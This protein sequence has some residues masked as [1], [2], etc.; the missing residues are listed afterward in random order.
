MA[1]N[2]WTVVDASFIRL[3]NITLGYNI[4]VDKLGPVSSLRLFIAGE[5]LAT[6]TNFKGYDP[7]ASAAGAGNVAKVNYNSY[8]LAR[9]F[10]LGVDVKF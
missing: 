5:N 3:K 2:S 4:P 10:R 9:V 1:I 8:P 7:D 6:I